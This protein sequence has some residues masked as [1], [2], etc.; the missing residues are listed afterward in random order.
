MK[1]L[2]FFRGFPENELWE[3]L[4]I[5]KWRQFK[6]DTVLIREGD[7][8]DSFFILANGSA[9]VTRGK[10]LLNILGAGDCFGEMSY[11]AK[12]NGPRSATITTAT[13]ALVIKI[14]AAAL[15]AASSRCRQL[16]DHKFLET[17]IE[18]LETANQQLAVT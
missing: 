5:S 3:V 8:G 13:Q 10:R 18:R 6:P 17:L 1:G 15:N 2:A 12:R 16:F 4:T 14:P 9:K 7:V 11:L